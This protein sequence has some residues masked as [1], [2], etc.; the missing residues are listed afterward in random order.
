M[1]KSLFEVMVLAHWC[2]RAWG[3]TLM[4]YGPGEAAGVMTGIK[5]VKEARMRTIANSI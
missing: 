3:R 5:G 1:V 4:A 2:C